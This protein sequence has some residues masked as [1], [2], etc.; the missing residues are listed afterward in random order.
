LHVLFVRLNRPDPAVP[1]RIPA[2]ALIDYRW[3]NNF[4][5]HRATLTATAL[6]IAILSKKIARLAT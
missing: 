3:L 2:I 4:A 6:S 1:Q 5:K